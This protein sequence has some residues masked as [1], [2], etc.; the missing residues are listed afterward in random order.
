MNPAADRL[1]HLLP[2]TH[3][4]TRPCSLQAHNVNLKQGG[5]PD[6]DGGSQ[7]DG[8]AGKLDKYSRVGKLLLQCSARAAVVLIRRVSRDGRLARQWKNLA[9]SV[10]ADV[11][12]LAQILDLLHDLLKTTVHGG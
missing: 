3:V 2:Q 10:R 1:S 5:M 11:H 8:D 9:S 7:V 4:Q 6:D 12:S